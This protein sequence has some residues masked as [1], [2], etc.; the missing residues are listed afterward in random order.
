M[1]LCTPL[2]VGLDVHKDSIAVAH[3]AGGSAEP[4]VFVGAIGPRQTDL[5]QLLRCLQGK[6]S[7]LVSLLGGCHGVIV[8]LL[9][10]E[11]NVAE[12]G[13]D[14]RRELHGRTQSARWRTGTGRSNPSGACFSRAFRAVGRWRQDC[15]LAIP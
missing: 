9:G 11:G 12:L 4:P 10:I 2:F 7:A 8:A 3:A 15:L 14:G 13:R 1:A 6:T 5:D